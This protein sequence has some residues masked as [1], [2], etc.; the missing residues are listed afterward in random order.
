MLMRWGKGK[1]GSGQARSRQVLLPR[2]AYSL[3][4]WHLLHISCLPAYLIFYIHLLLP[5]P[6]NTRLHTRLCHT[7]PI[8]ASPRSLSGSPHKRDGFGEAE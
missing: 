6:P 3:L 4:T 7:P 2:H 1:A 8:V 5:L